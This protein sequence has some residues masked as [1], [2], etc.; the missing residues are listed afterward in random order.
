MSQL[1]NSKTRKLTR[2]HFSKILKLPVSGTFY[3]VSTDQELYQHEGIL[4]PFDVKPIEFLTIATLRIVIDDPSVFPTVAHLLDAMLKL[5]D[6]QNPLLVQYLDSIDSCISIV[7]LLL[8]GVEAKKP[9]DSLVKQSIQDPEI[10]A[11][12]Q[13]KIDSLHTHSSHKGIK[14]FESLSST[15]KGFC[16]EKFCAWN[17]SNGFEVIRDPDITVYVSHTNIN[18][19]SNDQPS[20][21]ILEKTNVIPTWVS[22]TKSNME[23][24]QSP[25]IPVDLSDKD[26]NVNMGEGVQ[27][28]ESFVN[29]TFETSTIPISTIISSTLKTTT[30]ET[31]TTLLPISSP[32]TILVHVPTISPIH[33]I[34]MHEQ[35]TTLFSSQST[36]VEKV[37]YEEEPNDDE[38]MVSFVDL[39]FDPKKENVPDDLIIS[40]KKFKILNSKINCLLQIQADTGGRNFVT[41]VEMEYLLKSQE[42]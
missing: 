40:S 16:S 25:D 42:N 39:Q 38:M 15:R 19:N 28:K 1:T 35:I 17:T 14:R 11:T 4:A 12:E 13:T 27:N 6:P 18:I 22:T 9:N 7:V 29:S 10:E 37:I 8:K 36:K 31:S 20:I 23:V 2:K 33:F 3:E 34:I 32:I 41:R 21:S 5:V 24:V 30:V 26:T